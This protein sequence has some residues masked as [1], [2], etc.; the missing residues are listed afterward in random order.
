MCE[1]CLH[2]CN[3]FRMGS[4]PRHA[5]EWAQTGDGHKIRKEILR[6]SYSSLNKQ[7]SDLQERVQYLEWKN[8]VEI[9]WRQNTIK[10]N[11]KEIVKDLG[12]ELQ[13]FGYPNKPRTAPSLVGSMTE[14][15]RKPSTPSS[16]SSGKRP[17]VHLLAADRIIKA[18]TWVRAYVNDRLSPVNKQFLSRLKRKCRETIT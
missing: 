14:R 18:L 12:V 1:R 8:N 10:W 9:Q 15:S 7:I 4:K 5:D 3:W 17:K 13:Q 11:V 16:S 2:P 6:L